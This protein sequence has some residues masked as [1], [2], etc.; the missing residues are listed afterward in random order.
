VIQVCGDVAGGGV[1]AAAQAAARDAPLVRDRYANV[2]A[3]TI[4]GG[5]LRAGPWTAVAAERLC[6]IAVSTEPVG[7]GAELAAVRELLDAVPRGSASLLF[8][9]AAGVGK[10]T[11]LR[12]GTEEAERRG[13][14]VLSARAAE[15]EAESSFATVAD[16]LDLALDDLLPRLPGPQAEALEVAL[17]RRAPRGPT[18]ERA[19]GA[20]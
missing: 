10:T 9:G 13:M 17:L 3:G 12:F 6:G 11:L 15:P 14:A 7:R 8:R 19:V 5:R 2:P 1:K 20:A 18:T 4:L 16:L